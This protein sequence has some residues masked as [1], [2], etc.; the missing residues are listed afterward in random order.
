M[1]YLLTPSGKYLEI[2]AGLTDDQADAL[3]KKQFPAL[4]GIKPTALGQIREIPGGLAA[5]LVGSGTTMIRGLGALLP[6]EKEQ[7]SIQFAKDIEAKYSPTAAPGYED[8]VGRKLSEALGSVASFL[9]PGAGVGVGATRLGL[10]ALGAGRLAT[11][12]SGI[13]GS[14]AGAGEARI[15]AEE[16]KATPEQRRLATLGGAAIGLTEI[17]PAER[18]LRF[19]GPVEVKGAIDYIKNI[20]KSGGIEA[21]QEAASNVAQNL[22]AKQ[23]YKPEQAVFEGVG[24]AAAY[25][26]GAGAITEALLDLAIGRRG[27]AAAASQRDIEARAKRLSEQQQFEQQA[28][29]QKQQ[30]LEAGPV[31]PQAPIQ[32]DLFGG[33]SAPQETTPEQ[34]VVDPAAIFNRQRV[35]TRA[36]EE[37]N[38]R[39]N[40]AQDKGDTATADRL[41]AQLERLKPELDATNQEAK[42]AGVAPTDTEAQAAKLQKTRAGLLKKLEKAKEENNAVARRGIEQE[43]RNVDRDLFAMEG[44]LK[45]VPTLE[46]AYQEQL[47]AEIQGQRPDFTAKQPDLFGS[48]T[49]DLFEQ[50]QEL[51]KADRDRFFE[52]QRE[53]AAKKVAESREKNEESRRSMYV[54]EMKNAI[55]TQRPLS[56]VALSDG[57]TLSD[58]EL[59]GEEPQVLEEAAVAGETYTPK[60]GKVKREVLR[61]DNPPIVPALRAGRVTPQAVDLLG[62][63]IEPREYRVGV[64]EDN[65]TL[66]PAVNKRIEDLQSRWDELYVP[67]EKML[68]ANGLFTGEAQ[69]YLAAEGTLNELFNL[70]AVAEQAAKERAAPAEDRLLAAATSKEEQGP[71]RPGEETT[72][73]DLDLAVE[74]AATRQDAAFDGWRDDME[75]L[76]SGRVLGLKGVDILRGKGNT[77]ESL[78]AEI[79]QY[80]AAYIRATSEKVAAARA[81][82]SQPA[83]TVKEQIGLENKIDRE[84]SRLQRKATE[85]AQRGLKEP[86]SFKHYDLK[87]DKLE[88]YLERI[89]QPLENP[90]FKTTVSNIP[91]PKQ[92]RPR[93]AFK[94]EPSPAGEE[95]PTEATGL[96]AFALK[97][98]DQALNVKDMRTDVRAALE[99]AGRILETGKGTPELARA[100]LEQANRTIMG[101]DPILGPSFD[102]EQNLRL[103]RAAAAGKGYAARALERF[104]K[105]AVPPNLSYLQ[106]LLQ[107]EGKIREEG[108]AQEDLFAPTQ[109]QKEAQLKAQVSGKGEKVLRGEQG[110]VSIATMFGNIDR[111]AK[112]FKTV[113]AKKVEE[114]DAGIRALRRQI[115]VLRKG[116]KQI[117][118]EGKIDEQGYASPQDYAQVKTDIEGFQKQLAELEAKR[119]EVVTTTQQAIREKN[120]KT[121]LDSAKVRALRKIVDDVAKA[122]RAREQAIVNAVARLKQNIKEAE[123]NVAVNVGEVLAEERRIIKDAYAHEAAQLK[124]A[125]DYVA[126]LDALIKE[127]ETALQRFEKIL[128]KT[129]DGVF[130]FTTRELPFARQFFSIERGD[131][132]PFYTDRKSIKL[133]KDKIAELRTERADLT[134][135]LDKA[136][137]QKAKVDKKLLPPDERAT[138]VLLSL[139]DVLQQV[140]DQDIRVQTARNRLGL[141]QRKLAHAEKKLKPEIFTQV[142]AAQRELSAANQTQRKVENKLEEAQANLKKRGLVKTVR[143]TAATD[144]G[145]QLGRERVKK[146][147][148]KLKAQ[149]KDATGTKRDELAAQVDALQEQLDTG[150]FPVV[151][152]VRELVKEK[153][154]PLTKRIRSLAR[155]IEEATDSTKKRALQTERGRLINERERAKEGVRAQRTVT[156]VEGLERVVAP[157]ESPALQMVLFRLPSQYR[158]AVNKRENIKEQLDKV[159]KSKVKKSEA[160]KA[161][162]EKLKEA[163]AE[164]DRLKER[165]DK[166]GVM[167]DLWTPDGWKPARAAADKQVKDLQ[168]AIAAEKSAAYSEE[169]KPPRSKKLRAGSADQV[170]DAWEE[171][172]QAPSDRPALREA[173][174]TGL[175]LDKADAIIKKVRDKMPKGTN[176]V[177]SP[178][179]GDIPLALMRRFERAGIQVLNDDGTPAI[180]GA[181]FA[182][183]TVFVLGEGHTGVEDFQRTI[184]H[185]MIGHLSA[186]NLMGPEQLK[187]FTAELFAKG[188]KHVAELAKA[189]GVYDDVQGA[190]HT[191]GS[192]IQ[193]KEQAQLAIVREII[194]H[195]SEGRAVP[196]S[197][198][199]SVKNLWRRLVAY[200]QQAYRNLGLDAVVKEDAK[201]IQ[202]LIKDAYSSYADQRI[203]AYRA[204]GGEVALRTRS[205]PGENTPESFTDLAKDMIVQDKG[206]SKRLAA[207]V[208]GLDFITRYVDRLAPVQEIA[209]SMEDSNAATQMMYDLRMYDQRMDFTSSV[210]TNGYLSIDTETDPKTG[211]KFSVYNVHDGANLVDVAKLLGKANLGNP[212]YNEQMFTL[213]VAGLRGREV[214]FEKLNFNPEM[215]IRIKQFMERLES[216]P[217][218]KEDLDIFKEAAD[219]Y[220]KYNKG[221][222]NFLQQ[223]GA[224]SKEKAAQLNSI[225]NY[226]PYYR[227]SKDGGVNLFL[228]KEE[229]F[230]VGDLKNQPHLKEL[231]GGD[232]AIF[233]AFN[234]AIMNTHMIVDMGLRNAATK[235]TANTL[236][237]L[238]LGKIARGEGPA[239]RPDVLRFKSD[240]EDYF[241][242]VETEGTAFEGM[243][244]ELLVKGMEGVATLLPTYVQI[245]SMPA[246][247]LRKMIQ[248]PPTYAVNQI[249]KDSIATNF[250]TG[251]D[252]LPI[253]SATA[254]FAKIMAGK[255]KGEQTLRKSGVLAS[256]I[257][258]GRKEDFPVILREIQQG[259]GSF[260]AIA[261]M[262]NFGRKADAAS[263]VVL[264]NSFLKQGLNEMEA[265]LAALESMNFNKRGMSP[266]MYHLNMMIPFFNSSLQGLN[267]LVKSFKGTMPFNERLQAREKLFVRGTMLA[268]MT[269]AYAAA[270]S[271][272][273]WYK[274]LPE[275]DKLRYWF[276]KLPDQKEAVRI[277]IPF[278]IG[279][280][281]KAVPEALAIAMSEDKEAAPVLKALGN[282]TLSSLPVSPTNMIPAG[283]KP[284]AETFLAN[285]SFYTDKPIETRREQSLTPAERYRENTTE[286]AKLIGSFGVGV[287]PVQMDHLIYGYT[288]GLGLMLVGMLNP[289]FEGTAGVQKGE[290][291]D[292]TLKGI[293]FVSTFIEPLDGRGL[294]DRT[295]QFLEDA[296]QHENTFKKMVSEGRVDEAQSFLAGYEREV[297]FGSV[298]EK[299]KKEMSKITEVERVVRGDT[300]MSGAEKLKMLTQLKELKRD[301]AK[302]YSSL[303]E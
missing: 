94:L 47:T 289:V 121:F 114:Q 9:I 31:S 246:R 51:A 252:T 190:L 149:L 217:A 109:K 232:E 57:T 81:A 153:V 184:A 224:I 120:I 291:P 159:K 44:L 215:Q 287:S 5:G 193:N 145:I 48:E 110:P 60:T 135:I 49:R 243:D 8:T 302:A 212:T 244:P 58:K 277:P 176:F 55:I 172:Q 161:L 281:F 134:K 170:L 93:P 2:P 257:L 258:T 179:V 151:T 197:A 102:V 61:E 129:K 201:T 27:R 249:I 74:D 242:L 284:M 122:V 300:T 216:D 88:R 269:L 194:A 103:N 105:R 214:G 292:T 71:K 229:V 67:D 13:L 95:V 50:Q 130:K 39:A 255:S 143:R 150:N 239:K 272:E 200:V 237:D 167:L 20:F 166:Y 241:M 80:R 298:A 265:R 198:V 72:S 33:I 96:R 222:I 261:A 240:G 115:E 233:S 77:L 248:L 189:L 41:I 219:V 119:G 253:I 262:E 98:V 213:Y 32:P 247:A 231:I 42:A 37:L 142:Q 89:I 106:D 65:D 52:Q 223:S 101:L 280:L 211:E 278:E 84:L 202:A 124:Q 163:T 116:L 259:N 155:Q 87:L 24:E 36:I 273:D 147:L 99:Q 45:G 290:K 183:G 92:E 138:Q 282:L 1:P 227:A 157:D 181:V 107:Q 266:T 154:A 25:G 82:K 264:Y 70:Q 141:L 165:A 203:G 15:R 263:R 66:L 276:I 270:V 195:A 169:N 123:T 250:T 34:P 205:V 14:A 285:K 245:L 111:V 75:R 256:N 171:M 226:I 162:E 85:N 139:G 251:A 283:I 182:D 279:L 303:R 294:V 235:R 23:L 286:L 6:E 230:R 152:Q 62:L 206:M 295:Y 73:E 53:L 128:S 64:P 210:A 117:S 38:T 260:S 104:E 236:Q 180:A 22:L 29:V 297:V 288:S 4:Y 267:V 136:I 86:R 10:G 228:D 11:A 46:S 133:L 16:E 199:E 173:N 140:I 100:A 132:G 188:D 63:N 35:L 187:K 299:F 268:A 156:T 79:T 83:M 78:T 97:K 275:E 59:Y 192:S 127:K 144:L 221:L 125:A 19:L 204:P 91:S 234:S 293:P 207:R 69:R 68:D 90:T 21:A 186:E 131:S 148:D 191:L 7:Q 158:A 196:Q 168:K 238:K 126:E 301:T 177:Y 28:A 12:T 146:S 118:T 3:A 137:E 108:G 160:R 254:E 113:Q 40:E 296:N 30:A 274:E 225:K 175:D 174:G 56:G 112:L 18:F 76:A 185:E 209:G 17:L 178:T 208:S 271:D 43:L 218:L 220:S 164:T 26:G 54:R